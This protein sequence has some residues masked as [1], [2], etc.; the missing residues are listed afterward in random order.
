M[1][2]RGTD[3]SSSNK[4][5]RMCFNI[6][7]LLGGVLATLLLLG[8]LGF[9]TINAIAVQ[10]ANATNFYEIQDITSIKAN[11]VDNASKRVNK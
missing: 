11:S 8:I 9:L 1:S 6:N 7:G 5:R 3:I 2:V 4:T 10:K